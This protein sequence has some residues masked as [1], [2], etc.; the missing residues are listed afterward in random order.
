VLRWLDEQG[1][2]L[3]QKDPHGKSALDWS[4]WGGQQAAQEWLEQRARPR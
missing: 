4:R 3:S 1:V 2:D